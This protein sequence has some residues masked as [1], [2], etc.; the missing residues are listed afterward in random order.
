MEKLTVLLRLKTVFTCCDRF[1][2]QFHVCSRAHLVCNNVPRNKFPHNSLK[3]ID[4][5]NKYE[6]AINYTKKI[7]STYVFKDKKQRQLVYTLFFL[8]S[9]TRTGKH[10]LLISGGSVAEIIE[11][12]L[13]NRNCWHYLNQRYG[14]YDC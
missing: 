11:R 13:I 5:I 3:Q 4:R 1:C 7:Q 12:G 6:Y 8:Y 9:L 10:L 14:T 2:N